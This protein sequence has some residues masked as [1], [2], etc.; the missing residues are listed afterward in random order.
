MI[1]ILPTPGVE[2]FSGGF[3]GY[4]ISWNAKALLKNWALSMAHNVYV[5]KYT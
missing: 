4:N 5:K 3:A 1:T 2:H